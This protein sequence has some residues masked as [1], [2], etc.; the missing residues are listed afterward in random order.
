M[1]LANHSSLISNLGTSLHYIFFNALNGV[2]ILIAF[3]KGNSKKSLF[4]IKNQH[5]V[6]EAIADFSV[7]SI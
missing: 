5:L 4:N 2:G 7:Y 6:K 3:F 1:L